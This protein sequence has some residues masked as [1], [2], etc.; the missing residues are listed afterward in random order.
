MGIIYKVTLVLI[1]VSQRP[2]SCVFFCEIRFG[3]V[4]L[5]S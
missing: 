4:N 1:R 5:R 2:V 3:H